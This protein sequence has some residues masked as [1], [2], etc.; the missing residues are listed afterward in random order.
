MTKKEDLI[1]IYKE[2]LKKVSKVAGFRR[3]L[4]EMMEED[5]QKYF[6]SPDEL[7]K[8]IKGE[9]ARTKKIFDILEKISNEKLDN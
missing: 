2:D 6:E 9:R 5:I 8:T 7:H 4:K 3:F 1:E